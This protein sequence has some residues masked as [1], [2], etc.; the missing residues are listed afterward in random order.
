MPAE[1]VLLQN[2]AHLIGRLAVKADFQR[3]MLHIVGNGKTVSILL[4]HRC[5]FLSCSFRNSRGIFHFGNNHFILCHCLLVVLHSLHSSLVKELHNAVQI[6]DGLTHLLFQGIC[7]HRPGGVDGI[8]ILPKIADKFLDLFQQLL[9]ECLVIFSQGL[10]KG[11]IRQNI[12]HR[13]SHNLPAGL[14]IRQLILCL[15]LLDQVMDILSALGECVKNH[16][17]KLIVLDGIPFFNKMDKFM[18]ESTQ[19]G[20][21]CQVIRTLDIFQARIQINVDGAGFTPAVSALGTLEITLLVCLGTVQHN[22]NAGSLCNSAQQLVCLALSVVEGLFQISDGHAL[23]LHSALPAAGLAVCG[24]FVLS[25]QAVGFGIRRS[26]ASLISQIS[27]PFGKIAGGFAFHDI[28]KG[29]T[30]SAHIIG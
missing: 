15:H 13:L 26:F 4:N 16:L 28:V 8:E 11:R 17:S 29:H 9:E 23:A 7:F 5:Y 18:G 21:L 24:G 19:H 14:L 27:L 3:A 30:A 10:N 20:V 25:L 2:L 6:S 12:R 1:F 22:I